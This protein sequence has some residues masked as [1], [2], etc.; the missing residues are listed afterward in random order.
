MR[1]HYSDIPLD[2]LVQGDV[3]PSASWDGRFWNTSLQA[4]NYP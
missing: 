3:V 2:V 1:A 4:G